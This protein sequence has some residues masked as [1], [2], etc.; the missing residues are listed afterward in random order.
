LQGYGLKELPPFDLFL[1][2]F[3]QGLNLD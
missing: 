2:L 3:T 1:Q